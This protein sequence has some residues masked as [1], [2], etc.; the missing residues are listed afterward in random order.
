MIRIENRDRTPNHMR[1]KRQ[2]KKNMQSKINQ[3]YVSYF[4]QNFVLCG[5]VI[6]GTIEFYIK[7]LSFLSGK[8]HLFP[9]IKSKLKRFSFFVHTVI[10]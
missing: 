4:F 9:K 3:L 7:F 2:N 6:N 1:H 8:S 10:F 5:K